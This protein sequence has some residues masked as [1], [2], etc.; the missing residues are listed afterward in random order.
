MRRYV[1]ELKDIPKKYIYEPH[2]APIADQKKAGVL[3]KGNG[4]ETE[5]EEKKERLRPK[6]KRKGSS[7]LGLL[8]RWTSH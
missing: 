3:I 8:F 5:K 7:G 6:L 1:P 2:K 4:D